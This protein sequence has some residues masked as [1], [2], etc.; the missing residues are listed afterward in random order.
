MG[1]FFFN[2]KKLFFTERIVSAVGIVLTSLGSWEGK[3]LPSR[4]SK[5]KFERTN[6]H[7]GNEISQ[8]VLLPAVENLSQCSYEWTS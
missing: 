8:V 3:S 1:K 6:G 5:A 2:S 4:W 7:I